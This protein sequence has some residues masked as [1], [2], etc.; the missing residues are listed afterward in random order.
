MSDESLEVIESG[1]VGKYKIIKLIGEFDLNDVKSFD[2]KIEEV[3]PDQKRYIILDLSEL[4]YLDSSGIGCFVRLYR[5]TTIKHG[6]KFIVFQPK[7]FIKE[8]F[9]VSNL[10]QFWTVVETKKELEEICK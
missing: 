4:E 3:F 2:S 10:T 5:D 6:G 8:L 9:E 7:E 1:E